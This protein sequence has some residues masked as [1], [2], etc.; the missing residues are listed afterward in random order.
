VILI[1]YDRP[2][3][4]EVVF[5]LYNRRYTGKEVRTMEVEHVAGKHLGHA[6]L[7]TLSTCPWC[8]KT[9][10]LLNELGVEYDYIDVDYL[11]GAEKDKVLE[12]VRKWNP[13][14]SFPTLVLDDKK[15]IVGFKEEEIR[16]ALKK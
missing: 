15:C 13:A 5:G 7:Y 8:Q 4:C 9:K 6:M 11:D 14:C 3:D 2:P 16:K 12:D 1:S 10:K